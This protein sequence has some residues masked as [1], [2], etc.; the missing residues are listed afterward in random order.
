MSAA[1]LYCAADKIFRI[2]HIE[3]IHITQIE[4]KM[5]TNPL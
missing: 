4:K 5:L 1:H 3:I 2:P